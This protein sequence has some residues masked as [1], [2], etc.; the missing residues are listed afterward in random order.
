MS[1]TITPESPLYNHP[2]LRSISHDALV[3]RLQQIR[4]R[5]LVAA[6]Q[7]ESVRKTKLEK[8]SLSLREKWEKQDERNR[9]ALIKIDEMIDKFDA[10]LR[11]QIQIAH[12]L[13]LTEGEFKL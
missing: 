12:D 13:T 5:R 11:K 10:S 8:L 1:E 3:E 9:L 6:I 2:T 4:D 7:Y